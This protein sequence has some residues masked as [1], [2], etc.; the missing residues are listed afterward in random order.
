MPRRVG[1]LPP[2]GARW[3][4][5]EAKIPQFG[6]QMEANTPQ[7]VIEI[8]QAARAASRSLAT[9]SLA[10]RH[11]VL[12]CLAASLRESLPALLAANAED[13]AAARAGGLE[14]STYKRLILDGA[15]VD[16]LLQGLSD[17]LALPDPLG[18]VG[19]SRS[20]AEG[21]ELRRVSC[22]LGVLAIIFE[23]R[24][25][26]VVQIA[27]LSLLSGNA[28]ILKGGKEAAHSNAALVAAVRAAIAAAAAAQGGGGGAPFSVP[29]DAVQLV[30]SRE[31]VA[32]L[33]RLDDLID[34][35][36]PRGSLRL[37]REVKAA[38]RI[39][40]LGHADGICHVYVDV[41]AD[42]R[43][44]AAL[45]VDS[46]TNYPAACNAA[47]TLL[48]H[49]DCVAGGALAAVGGALL[50][51]GVT[52]HADGACAPVL[53]AARAALVAGR[54][55]G[56]EGLGAVADAAPGDWR[57]EWLSLHMGVAAVADVGAAVA[58][59]NAHGSH[60]TDCVVVGEGPAGAA[61]AARFTAG[62]DSAGVYV[63]ASTRFA[64]GF[65]YGFGAEVGISTNRIHARGPVG[66]EGLTTYKYTLR[67]RGHTVAQ[68]GA[69]PG[70][71]VEVGGVA[72]PALA[73]A[74]CDHVDPELA[75]A[76]ARV[77]QLEAEVAR[78]SR[79]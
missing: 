30:G 31:A 73:F 79:G 21:L 63:N 12:R 38:T 25:E 61:A 62:V 70:G 47:E 6:P 9:S 76:H 44:A 66:L 23:A 7:A 46:K 77:A 20:L 24:P 36:I 19:L 15:K 58:W 50:A 49:A 8:A 65:R 42:A 27:A 40:V 71:A 43:V 57:T 54:P 29:P 53:R 18:R 17:L 45:A 64:D 74:H 10:D 32:D 22:P 11:L 3:G 51:A 41:T 33:L 37:V 55:R 26:A 35:V 13:L 34:L 68:F 48:V 72:L 5:A 14:A 69:P 67:G 59:V 52:L 4:T 16:S 1:V 75:A 39:P 2:A 56:E 78:L 28:V 60:H